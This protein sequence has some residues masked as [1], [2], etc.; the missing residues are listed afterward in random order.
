M[1]IG[2]GIVLGGIRTAGCLCAGS[3]AVCAMHSMQINYVTLYAKLFNLLFVAPRSAS[4]G[5]PGTVSAAAPAGSH[6]NQNERKPE[7]TIV[8]P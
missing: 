5:Q 2:G 1:G 8:L 6:N 4:V 3:V 7:Q